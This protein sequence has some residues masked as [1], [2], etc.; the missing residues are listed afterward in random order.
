MFFPF[1]LLPPRFSLHIVKGS[2][3]R[4]GTRSVLRRRRPG[5]PGPGRPGKRTLENGNRTIGVLT[6]GHWKM[7]IG[8]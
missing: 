6:A 7:G 1:S 8:H 2:A 4:V 5:R 3:E